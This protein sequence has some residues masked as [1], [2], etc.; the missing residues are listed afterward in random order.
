MSEKDNIILKQMLTSTRDELQNAT[1]HLNTLTAE[2]G[3]IKCLQDE[4]I[5]IYYH[6]S[7]LCLYYCIPT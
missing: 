7:K 3:N 4:Y 1:I 5:G 2:F 6:I